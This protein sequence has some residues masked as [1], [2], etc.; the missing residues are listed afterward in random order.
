MKSRVHL[1][2]LLI[3]LMFGA[4]TAKAQQSKMSQNLL[5]RIQKQKNAQSKV[6]I[7]F[8]DKGNGL[9]EK[10]KNVFESLPENSKKRRAKTMK[11][12]KSLVLYYD[13]P[14]EQQYINSISGFSDK[15]MVISRWLN[16]VSA[17]V[18]NENIEKIA[19]L[20]YVQKIDL[21]KTGKRKNTPVEDS[22]L[23]F[24]FNKS[25]KYTLNYGQ[26]LTQ[27]EQINVP[28]V[29][30][31]GYHGENV[32]ICVMDAGFNNL[33]HDV[34]SS[35][36]IL[37]QYDFVHGDANVD[38]EAGETGHGSHGTM[39]LSTIGGFK[40]GSLIGPAYA[41]K[42]VLAKTEDYVY[43]TTQEED[44]WVAAMQWAEYY[45]GPDVISSSLGYITFDDGSGYSAQELNGSTAVITNAADA[46]GDL[47]ILVVN[48]AGNEGPGAT[49]IGAPADGHNVLSVGAVTSSGTQS[50]F[51]SEGPTGDGRIKPDIMAMGSSVTVA[52]ATSATTY[53]T[54]S[55]T[56]FSCP[57]TAGAAAL[58]VQM[59][60]N[61]SNFQ[62]MDAIRATGS[63]AAT[64]DNSY[65]WGIMNTLAAYNYLIAPKI[66]HAPA[67]LYESLTGP[68]EIT[69]E[70]SSLSDLLSGN[71]KLFYR[72][73]AGT[74]VRIDPS[75]STPG[76][77]TA[78]IPGTGTAAQYDYYLSAENAYAAVTLPANAPTGYFTFNTGAD[79]L[80]PVITHTLLR[81]YY[82]NLW[83]TAVIKADLSDNLGVDA[84]NSFVEWKIN[85]T[86]QGNLTFHQVSGNKYEAQFPYISLQTGD[87]IEY[88]IKC[89]DI[90]V[91]G[92]T[93][94]YPESG[95]QSFP[96]TDRISFEQIDP[97]SYWNF[98]GDAL[99]TTTP[100]FAQHGSVSLVS[101]TIT[102]SQSTS[103]SFSFTSTQDGNLSFYKKVSCEDAPSDNYDFLSFSIDG[104]EKGLWDGEL[105]WELHT[106]PIT[107]GV[108]TV[109]WDYVK[110]ISVSEGSDCAWIDNITLPDLSATGII[111]PEDEICA[112]Y[113]NPV[114]DFLTVQM[115]DKQN[116]QI[117]L[118]N[119][120]GQTVLEE[121]FQTTRQFSVTKLPDGIY[122]CRVQNE[123]GIYTT[124]VVIRK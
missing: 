72:A 95:F 89:K 65:G 75:E 47:G 66:T 46:A 10:S 26:S 11:N 14:V 70:V 101:G 52:S 103:A 29:H 57:L 36:T 61:A 86:P 82:K 107:A 45:Y 114:R 123:N 87:V 6:W 35:M 5:S 55:G 37:G 111:V 67:M 124:K 100:N 18:P 21:V 78:S 28:A 16:A 109:K 51:S 74:W 41:A 97:G 91:A 60:P 13:L 104:V 1:F 49:S 122:F 22:K 39:T 53:T 25:S 96:I 62:I 110:D 42:Y 106:Y 83:N 115:T 8:T 2:S 88:R 105:N 116:S 43:E 108:H 34:F 56:S 12:N 119:L 73:N 19:A 71:P 121:S 64:P 48:S 63:R 112:I 31:L 68:Y 44:N 76:T 38:D 32:I 4:F 58:L 50:S 77:W 90:S 30:D 85:S 33:E 92:N 118:T 79:N 84:A 54:N 27:N 113:P 117:T 15:I 93:K 20:P 81:D 59:V 9:D 7:Y 102:D 40:S 98:S 24:Q 99:W 94:Y 17:Y 23:D 120:M 3:I 69:F 80:A